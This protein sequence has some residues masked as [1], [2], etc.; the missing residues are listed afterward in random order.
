MASAK[1]GRR[2]D[3]R[4]WRLQFEVARDLARYVAP[5]GSICIDGVSLTVNGVDGALFDVNVIPHT[6]AVTTLGMLRPGG[7]VNV[8]V[9]VIARYLRRL[10]EFKP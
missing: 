1:Q 3:G 2:E 10:V 7:R 4:S 8:E 9:D 5:K 6:L